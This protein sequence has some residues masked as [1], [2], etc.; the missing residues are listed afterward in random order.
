MEPRLEKGSIHQD[1]R[2][3]CTH[4]S[5]GITFLWIRL[6]FKKYQKPNDET[7]QSYLPSH[8]ESE[9][10]SDTKPQIWGPKHLSK[11]LF[12]VKGCLGGDFSDSKYIQVYP[13][14]L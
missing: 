3:S 14:N 4:I 6:K 2:L 10:I 9:D 11:A 7:L 5:W 13:T 1:G 8:H 12:R